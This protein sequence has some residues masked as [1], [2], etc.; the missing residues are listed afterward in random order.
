MSKHLRRLGKGIPIKLPFDDEG[1]LGRVCP[2]GECQKYFKLTPGTGLPQD[3]TRCPY[4]GH[5]G[6]QSE[7]ATK[8]QMEYAVSVAKRKVTDA[9][10]KDL[11][12]LE[13]D[14]HP[15]GELGIGFSLKVKAGRPTPIRYYSEETLETKVV[16]DECTLRYAIYGVFAFCPDCGKHNSL[17]ILN[18]N[19]E[20][21]EKQIAL[22]ASVDQDL[23]ENLIADALENVVSAFDG[24]GREVCRVHAAA[25]SKPDEVERVSFQNLDG[26]RRR[27]R[28]LFGF[29][30][31][32]G[33]EPD[34]WD[35]ACIQFQKRHLVVHKAGVIDEGYVRATGSTY[36]ML[37]RKVRIES[38][39]VGRLCG[40][41]RKLGT[42]LV[43]Q[44]H[45]D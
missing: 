18:K 40:V 21:V 4:C 28:D 45:K 6:D 19:L 43:G 30:L 8:E 42:S 12:E 26:A 31:A 15:R 32:A 36:A 39:E 13:F 7:F 25:A 23:A 34:E 2:N 41:I 1:Y 44:L 22:A 27:V 9:I 11:K 3:L 17:Q 24:F 20:L 37:G 33:V 5:A 38:G 10:V 29:N 16:C 35:F 14:Y